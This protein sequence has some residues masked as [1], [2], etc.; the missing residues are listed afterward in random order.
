MKRPSSNFFET[1]EEV[2]KEI[3]RIHK[4]QEKLQRK[5]DK[6]EDELNEVKRQCQ[7]LLQKESKELNLYGKYLKAE[8]DDGSFHIRKI[9]EENNSPYYDSV[10]ISVDFNQCYYTSHRQFN[11]KQFL[12]NPNLSDYVETTKEDYEY[13]K[14]NMAD[15]LC[16]RLKKY[17]K[18]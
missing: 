16:E 6:L 7:D 10:N 17:G 9:Y 8:Y 13:A 3:A 12:M 4:E 5:Q 14:Q 2:D 15:I 1:V 18:Y 11:L